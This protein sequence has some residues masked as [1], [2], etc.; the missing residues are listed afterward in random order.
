MGTAPASPP[1]ESREKVGN[2]KMEAI[3]KDLDGKTLMELLELEMKAK[4]LREL[5]ESKDSD[6]EVSTAK[7]RFR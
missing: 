3:E 6:E 7:K 2:M 4:A 5:I 1:K